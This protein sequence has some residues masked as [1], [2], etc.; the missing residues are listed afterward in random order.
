M[1]ASQAAS[2]T[3]DLLVTKGNARPSHLAPRLG[4]RI[5]LG[6]LYGGAP[7]RPVTPTNPAAPKAEPQSRILLR[8]DEKRRLRLRLAAV[9]LGKSSQAILL[10]ALDHY[11]GQ[12]MPTL[13]ADRCPCIEYG[14]QVSSDACCGRID[15]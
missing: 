6:A 1:S 13:L 2:L 10:D 8:I 5:A 3:A 14:E 9:H 11:L 7:I 15:T 4:D 12:I